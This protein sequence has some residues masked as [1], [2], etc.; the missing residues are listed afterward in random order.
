MKK[1]AVS[2]TLMSTLESFYLRH[3]NYL[4]GLGYEIFIL[5]NTRSKPLINFENYK[6]INIPYSRKFYHPINLIALFNFRKAIKRNGIKSI[7]THTPIASAVNR[8]ALIGMDAKIVYFCHGFQFHSNSSKIIYAFFFKIEKFLSRM[9]DIGVFINNYDYNIALE[10]MHFKKTLYVKGIGLR[11]DFEIFFDK[12]L[13]EEQSNFNVFRITSIGELNN[14]KNVYNFLKFYRT[15]IRKTENYN[16]LF[17]IIGEGPNKTRIQKFIK[18]F[19]LEKSVSV[20]GYRKQVIDELK[21][22]NLFVFPSIREGFGMA[23]LESLYLGIPSIA[24]NIRGVSEFVD[25]SDKLVLID[26]YKFDDFIKSVDF[27]YNQFLSKNIVKSNMTPKSKNMNDF[28]F[29]SII[30]DLNELYS[31][32]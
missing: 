28:K 11:K 24:F 6:V 14:N 30:K 20:L 12:S 22:T 5:T 16:I 18:K 7:I 4:T 8:L 29:H 1:L 32:L 9:T 10:R 26:A 17:T 27:H 3:L 2:A 13:N 23:L 21:A 15:Y 19:N 25:Y 31:S